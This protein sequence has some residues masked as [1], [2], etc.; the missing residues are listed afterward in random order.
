MCVC[1]SLSLSPSLSLSLGDRF[2]VSAPAGSVYVCGENMRRRVVPTQARTQTQA[3]TRGTQTKTDLPK[4]MILVPQYPHRIRT[5]SA[6]ARTHT[7]CLCS[8]CYLCSHWSAEGSLMR[9]AGLLIVS[10]WICYVTRLV[11]VL[12]DR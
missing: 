4:S 8:F 12:L 7:H 11:D 2:L 9:R 1:V 6:R 3:R 10:L 5:T